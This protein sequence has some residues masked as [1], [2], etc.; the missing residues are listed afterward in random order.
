MFKLTNAKK[1]ASALKKVKR[2]TVSLRE[3]KNEANLNDDIIFDIASYFDPIVRMYDNYNFRNIEH[4]LD[5]YL[6]KQ[7][8]ERAKDNIKKPTR[9]HKLP[10]YETVKDFILDKMILPGGIIDKAYELSDDDLKVLKKTIN[11]EI[12][13]RKNKNVKD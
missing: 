9:R 7:E 5:N 3:I 10:K 6:K 8:E 2:K 12:K 11:V 13:E 1:V 4:D